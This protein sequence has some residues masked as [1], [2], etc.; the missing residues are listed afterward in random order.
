MVDITADVLALIAKAARIEQ[1]K[2]K[3]TDKLVEMGIESL[4]VIELTFALE[5]K[6]DIQVPYNANSPQTQFET[7]GD[8]VRAVMELVSN[9]A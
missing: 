5:E 2:V 1:S 9:K 8:V 3:L 6:F 4:D 7:V